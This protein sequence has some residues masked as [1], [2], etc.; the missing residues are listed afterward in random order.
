MGTGKTTV[1][2]IVAAK[3]SR[4][5]VEMDDTIEKNEKNKITD[6]FNIHGEKYFRNCEYKLLKELARE[7]NLIVSCGGGL[8]CNQDNLEVLKKSGI[9]FNL[10]ASEDVIYQRTKNNSDRPLLAGPE[11]IKKIRELLSIR[12][13]YYSQANYSIDTDKLSPEAVAES[14]IAAIQSSC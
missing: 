13:P 7:E 14:V 5:F 4:K 3:L 11:P 1:G 8:I 12:K 10:S 2:R 6:I 9:I